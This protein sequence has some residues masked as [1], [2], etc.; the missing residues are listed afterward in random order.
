MPILVVPVLLFVSS[1]LL[2]AALGGLVGFMLLNQL[3]FHYFRRAN[4]APV[5]TSGDLLRAHLWEMIATIRVGWW[6]LRSRLAWMPRRT[7]NGPAVL[8]VHGYTQNETN[9]WGMRHALEEAGRHTRAVGL[10]LPWPWRRV[11]GYG[12]PLERALERGPA[13][14]VAHSM[15]GVVLRD[16]LRRRPDLRPHVQSVTT[17]GSPHSGTAMAHG[18]RWF[19][20][21][22]D[23]AWQSDFLAAL[24]TLG[25]LLPDIA[26]LT[27]AGSA[28]M[29]VYPHATATQPDVPHLLLD[30]V[31]HAG[32]LTSKRA[33]E[34]VV[35]LVRA[36]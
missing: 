2:A 29:V 20:P 25:E 13:D 3:R 23:I 24:P 8:F 26:L 36:G 4:G 1:V 9:F 15:G 11:E 18:F 7:S 31:G 16:V 28:D 22:S 10:G 19:Q 6:H 32:L 27:I 33:I 14:V 17:L 34:A 12:A 30:G 21:A 5:L 35:E